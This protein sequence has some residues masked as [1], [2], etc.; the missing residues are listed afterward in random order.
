MFGNKDKNNKRLKKKL[1]LYNIIES[2]VLKKVSFKFWHGR[3][4]IFQTF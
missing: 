3:P 4:H 1:A 2:I